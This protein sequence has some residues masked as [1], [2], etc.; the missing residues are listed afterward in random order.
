[1]TRCRFDHVLR[2]RRTRLQQIEYKGRL[3]RKRPF[4]V[5]GACGGNLESGALDCCAPLPFADSRSPA[6]NSHLLLA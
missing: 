3:F 4:A 6:C 2:A 1:M 5:S